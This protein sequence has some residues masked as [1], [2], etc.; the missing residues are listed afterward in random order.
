MRVL[1]Q[2]IV[3]SGEAS[4]ANASL[5]DMQQVVLL[6]STFPFYFFF[7][8]SLVFFCFMYF[9]DYSSSIILIA[10]VLQQ[11]VMRLMTQCNEKAFELEVSTSYHNTVEILSRLVYSPIILV[12][13]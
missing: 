13:H 11:T 12:S 7:F 8:F 2:H 10:I 4:M 6:S 5:V 3:E 9:S 1:E